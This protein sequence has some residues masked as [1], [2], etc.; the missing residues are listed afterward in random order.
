MLLTVPGGAGYP[1]TAA[2]TAEA[3]S[4]FASDTISTTITVQREG[5]LAPAA[6]ETS[7]QPDGSS[8]IDYTGTQFVTVG[9]SFTVAAQLRQGLA[10]ESSDTEAVDFGS[11]TVNAVISLYPAGC[12]TTC[13]T[14]PTTTA[15]LDVGQRQGRRRRRRSGD[16]RS[17][18]GPV[19]R[20]LPR[21]RDG[22]LQQLHPAAPRGVDAHGRQQQRAHTSRAAGD[23]DGLDVQCPVE[24]RCVRLQRPQRQQRAVRQRDLRLPD[25][26]GRDVGWRQRPCAPRSPA[27]AATWTSSSG[28]APVGNFVPG[29]STTYPLTSYETG[30]ATVQYIDA[31]D[32]SILPFGFT[33]A[34]YRLDATDYGTTGTSDTF[35]FSVYR[36]GTLFHQAAT[37]ANAQNGLTSATNQVVLS[38]GNLTLKPK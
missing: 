32:G 30:K 17:Q 33:G 21:R 20:L 11:V 36:A 25:A 28:S 4:S 34:D 14:P 37:G 15:G 29:Q 13:P 7:G 35:G 8:R 12:G 23:R 24:G 6:G 3:G 22:H 10:P 1:A 9:Q 26:D 5:Q 2:F 27:P 31:A 16:D 18:D 38:S 19:R